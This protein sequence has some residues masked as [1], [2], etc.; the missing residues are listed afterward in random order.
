MI[1][2]RYTAIDDAARS[3]PQPGASGPDW[4]LWPASSKAVP[5]APTQVLL[6]YFGGSKES[7]VYTAP[8]LTQY[9]PV[10]CLDLPGFGRAPPLSSPSLASMVQALTG[11]IGSH[12][13]GRIRLIGHSMSAKLATAIAL[14]SLGPRL[15]ELVL[16]APSPPSIEPMP[17]AE[18][19]RM[20]HHPDPELARESVLHSSRLPLTDEQMALA[21]ATQLVIDEDTWDWW[22][23]EGMLEPLHEFLTKPGRL[24][25]PT[26][27]LL[28][29]QDPAIL[30]E[31]QQRETVPAYSGARV[32]H[33]ETAGHLLPLEAPD[34]VVEQLRPNTAKG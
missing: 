21:V 12:V 25:V 16:V 17:A 4:M 28:A 18:K 10:L 22:L 33:H 3:A 5:N 7:W 34:W 14:G 8:K 23:M 32:V 1:D 26:T 27:I 9:G 2:A 20:R 15:D 13:S 31:V 24:T 29:D 11:S 30:L 19:A 6:H